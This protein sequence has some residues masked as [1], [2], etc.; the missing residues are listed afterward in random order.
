[1]KRNEILDEE[2]QILQRR[3]AAGGLRIVVE[4]GISHTAPGRHGHRRT[5]VLRHSWISTSA[6]PQRKT[7]I[8]PPARSSRRTTHRTASIALSHKRIRHS[9]VSLAVRGREEE[10]LI[11]TRWQPD[12]GTLKVSPNTRIIR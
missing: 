8:W 10:R 12:R 4:P 3:S 9:D 6:P 5:V 2:F 11:A 7:A 1:V